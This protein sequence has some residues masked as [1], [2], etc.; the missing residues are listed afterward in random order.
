MAGITS[1]LRSTLRAFSF[2]F[3]RLDSETLLL[4]FQESTFQRIGVRFPMEYLRRSTVIGLLAPHPHLQG[5]KTIAGGYILAKSGPLRALEQL[6][7]EVVKSS[8][9]LQTRVHRCLEV[10]GLWIEHSVAPRWARLW[11][12]GNC[13]WRLVAS[14]FQ[15]KFYF[16][17]SFDASKEKLERL[18]QSF[19]PTRLFHGEVKMLPG[20][21]APEVEIVE[22]CS[23]RRVIVAAFSQPQ[24]F[25]CRWRRPARLR[26]V[27]NFAES[28]LNKSLESGLSTS[29]ET[30]SGVA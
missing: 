24:F 4:D 16:V 2:C 12:W 22:F 6:P 13:F 3:R 29:V 10:N 8:R 7:D 17:Y 28:A 1:L 11:L 30:S 14:V 15:G 5:Q 9:F 21:K 27:R 20:M 18:Y 19:G 25:F 26:A 23:V